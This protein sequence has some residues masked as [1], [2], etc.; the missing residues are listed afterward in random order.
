MSVSVQQEPFA[1]GAL[2]EQVQARSV[3]AGAVAS[4]AGLV[5]DYHEGGSV[6]ALFLEHYPG[7]TEKSLQALEV[8]ARTRWPLQEVLIVHRY[9]LLQ[10]A[11]PIVFVGVSSAHRK[12]AFEACSYLM[13]QLKTRAPFW[14]KEMDS[15]QGQWVESKDS[16]LEAARRW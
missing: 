2:L 9:G 7:M 13:D 4:F 12:A 10:P 8:E 11:E 5:R 3:G 16:D 1:S 14:K 6:S 15:A